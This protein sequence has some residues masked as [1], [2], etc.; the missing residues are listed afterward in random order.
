MI[1]GASM[2]IGWA[3]ARPGVELARVE[4]AYLEELERL[5]HEPVTADELARA[6]ALVETD[7]LGALQRV[8]ERADRLSMYATLLNDPGMINRQL[9]RYLAITPEAI[10]AAATEVFRTENRIVLTY[11]PTPPGESATAAE[12]NA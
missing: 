10:Q 1:E 11:L 5:T 9:G 2:T 6:K 12:A 7:E 3:T 4:A 8:E